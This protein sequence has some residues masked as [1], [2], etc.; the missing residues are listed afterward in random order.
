[1]DIR[2]LGE[3]V[4]V[5]IKEL[6][7]AVYKQVWISAT[8]QRWDK[9]RVLDPRALFFMEVKIPLLFGFVFSEDFDTPISELSHSSS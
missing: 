6:L 1:M 4:G 8:L 5:T 7:K 9:N 3:Y 2:N